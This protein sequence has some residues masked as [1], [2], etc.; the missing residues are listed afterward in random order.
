[1][2]RNHAIV[3]FLFIM[4][5]GAPIASLAQCHFFGQKMC[6]RYLEDYS[7]NGQNNTAS[8]AQGETTHLQ[9]IFYKSHD[10]RLV[11]CSEEH[12]GE[13]GIKI[14]TSKGEVLFDNADHDMAFH[15]DFSM[16][17]TQRFIIEVTA[18]GGSEEDAMDGCVAIALGVRPSIHKG[19]N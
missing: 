12:L 14:T 13:L 3:F 17:R 2:R 16:K 5:I 10:Y 15:W 6:V 11:F 18:P 9:M 7:S 8:M 4:V 19:F 1:M